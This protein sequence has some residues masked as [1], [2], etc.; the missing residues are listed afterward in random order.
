[1]DLVQPLLFSLQATEENLTLLL[2]QLMQ[3]PF[4][5]PTQSF[6]SSDIL[7]AGHIRLGVSVDTVI[8]NLLSSFCCKGPGSKQADA[9]IAT[10][11]KTAYTLP[12]GSLTFQYKCQNSPPLLPIGYIMSSAPVKEESEPESD[13][14]EEDVTFS[15]GLTKNPSQSSISSRSSGLGSSTRDRSSTAHE[16]PEIPGISVE[17]IPI[18]SIRRCRSSSSSAG[19]RKHSTAGLFPWSPIALDNGRRDSQDSCASILGDNQWQ[20]ELDPPAKDM[21]VGGFSENSYSILMWNPKLQVQFE[22]GSEENMSR[23]TYCASSSKP[24]VSLYVLN[25][26]EESIAFSVRAYR[27]SLMF[28]SHVIYPRV[29]LHILNSKEEFQQDFDV[30]GIENIKRDDHII[31]DL[32]VC[33]LDGEPSWNLQRRY[34]ILKFDEEKRYNFYCYYY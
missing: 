27:Q 24:I 13:S 6:S 19:G 31:I 7:S 22:V 2:P 15:A 4:F 32:M 8:Y 12:T 25:D 11:L 3:N 23:F 14:S 33:K 21:I 5:N 16:Y 9:L 17:D 18:P 28:R 34:V 20:V 30:V 1:M 26:Q 10:A 29:G